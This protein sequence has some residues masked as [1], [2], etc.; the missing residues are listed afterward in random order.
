MIKIREKKEE[1]RG[2]KVSYYFNYN[3][4]DLTDLVGI[5]TVTLQGLPTREI[6]TLDIWNRVGT[7]FNGVKNGERTIEVSF[8]IKVSK[9]DYENDPSIIYDIE[10]DIRRTLYINEPQPLYI[11]REDIYIN[12]IATGEMTVEEL[13]PYCL[14]CGVTFTC[15]DPIFYSKEVKKFEND[16]LSKAMTVTNDGTVLT[17]PLIELGFSQD[18]HYVSITNNTTYQTLLL[19]RYPVTSKPTVKPSSLVFKDP[20]EKTVNWT[21]GT[22][23]IDVGRNNKGTLTSTDSGEGLTVGDYGD[24][25]SGQWYGTSAIANLSSKVK[26]F[27]VRTRCSINSKGING[28]PYHVTNKTDDDKEMTKTYYLRPK[29]SCTVRASK[30]VR[31]KKIGVIT[32][33][34]KITNLTVD[35]GWV[36]I[37]YKGKTGYVQRS[38][39]ILMARTR[40]VTGTAKN[41]VTTM[42]TAIRTSPRK[43]SKNV[44][45]IPTGKVIRCLFSNPIPDPDKP[46]RKYY[47]LSKKYSNGK[48]SFS[49]YIC[50]TNAVQAS[51]VEF[52]WE[53]EI[54][55]ADNK[56]GIVEI[57]GY[58][59]IGTKLFKMMLCDESE[60]Y[61]HVYPEFFIGPDSIYSYQKNEPSPNKK[62]TSSGNDDST[63]ITTDYLLSGKYGSFNE[64]Y[65]EL[66]VE[67]RDNDWKF[68]VTK[69]KDDKAVISK[70]K[71]YKSSKCSEE[72]ASIVIYMGTSGDKENNVAVSH[73]EVTN[74]APT[75]SLTNSN[76]V[77]FEE[78]DIL[79]INC[80]E[81]IAYLNGKEFYDIDVGSDFLELDCGENNLLIN[82]NDQAIDISVLFNERFL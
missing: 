48:K 71:T 42:S 13:A 32:K 5:R 40:S 58:S 8:L 78:G 38:S 31:G 59:S 82:T 76:I 46:T 63:K 17:M 15:C 25:G 74:L 51:D 68:N 3:N 53:E 36:K 30:S 12:A 2:D 7:I 6:D 41:F 47:K 11:G 62:V 80:A 45:T 4:V 26:N 77:A 28:D 75:T 29:K 19:G 10:Q 81:C 73:V 35:K 21:V 79:S 24:K 44:C 65:G 50:V 33:S 67:R 9:F 16:G 49:G 34:Y 23:L 14:Q 61:E 56:Q 18:A 55:T 72:L 64:F 57:Y 20:M 39:L 27:K 54:D 22:S 1:A 43:S 37:T 60:Y 70:T 69:I 66:S 52:E